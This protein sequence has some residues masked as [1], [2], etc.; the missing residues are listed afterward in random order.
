MKQSTNFPYD[1]AIHS[2]GLNELASTS[3]TFEYDAVLPEYFTTDN[4]YRPIQTDIDFIAEVNC[5]ATLYR[6]VFTSNGASTLLMKIPRDKVNV[7]FTIDLLLVANKEI[8]WDSQTLNKGMPIAHFGSFKKD[9]DNRS[10]GLISFEATEGEEITISNVDHTIRIQIPQ[11]QYQYLSSGQNSL[12]VKNILTSQFAQIALLESCKEL[13]ENSK[14]DNLI[15]YK[16]LLSRWRDFSGTN[17][18]YPQE[19]DYLKFVTNLLESP[20]IKLIDYLIEEEKANQ[21]E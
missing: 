3:E 14:R 17:E 2:I 7:S 15:W 12:L 18:G 8:K 21:D 4:K 16:E 10:T 6:E 5:S 19:T 1:V 11:K 13:K 20:S 9:I